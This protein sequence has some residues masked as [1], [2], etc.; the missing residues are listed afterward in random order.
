MEGM[1]LIE[2]ALE[3]RAKDS[4]LRC[5]IIVE[6]RRVGTIARAI[7]G[8]EV[9]EVRPPDG[10]PPHP[11]IVVV[12]V[13]GPTLGKRWDFVLVDIELTEQNSRWMNES[14]LTRIVRGG[15]VRYFH[16]SE[17]L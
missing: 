17:V 4:D 1:R 3:A 13:C 8:M 16:R 10:G 2:M 7:A 14:V 11:A 9:G 6:A 5:A 12:G 15:E